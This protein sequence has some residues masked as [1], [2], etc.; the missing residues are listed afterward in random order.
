M[1]FFLFVFLLWS[2][3]LSAAPFHN[4]KI[5]VFGSSVAMGWG[6]TN[7]N[8]GW[9]F[10]LGNALATKGY[11]LVNKSIP[12]N[13]TQALIGRFE[14]DL[15]PEKPEICVIALGLGNEGIAKQSTKEGKDSVYNHFV[16]GINTLIAMCKKAGII[17]VVTGCYPANIFNA[18]DYAFVKKFN[19]MMKNSGTPFIDLLEAVDDGSGHFKEGMYH[20]ALHPNDAGHEAMFQGIPLGIFDTLDDGLQKQSAFL[21]GGDRK[22]L[23]GNY[24]AACVRVCK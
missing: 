1:R 7:N 18:D 11:T 12:G 6:S 16:N 24:V 23:S 8:Q 4:K 13:N 19:A 14:R 3:T 2:M 5:V 22:N 15:L 21:K 10:R 20:D 9:A 17:P